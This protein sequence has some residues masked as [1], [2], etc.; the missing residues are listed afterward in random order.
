MQKILACL[1][2]CRLLTASQE[3][4]AS[5]KDVPMIETTQQIPLITLNP[6]EYVIAKPFYENCNIYTCCLHS[7]L[8]HRN[9][10]TVFTDDRNNPTFFLVCSPSTPSNLNAPV[11]LAGKLDQLTLKKI[12]SFLKTFPKISLVAPMNWEHRSLFEEAGFKA[13]ERL[14][15]KRPFQSFD[16]S[17]WKESLPSHYSV[18]EMNEKNFTQCKW[19]PFVLSCYGDKDRFFTTGVGFCILDQERVI[20]ESYGLFIAN[21]QA[22]IGVI[23]DPEYRGQNLGT[24]GCA[25]ML[26]YCYKNNLE[27]Y[28]NCDVKNSASAAIAKKLGFEEDSPYLFLKWITP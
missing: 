1:F 2:A 8:E 18:A 3:N 24:I 28:W 26:D 22:E 11:Y 4:H 27:P 17:S 12:A 21:G 20:S 25:I 13:V 6:E 14:Q 16:M 9:A 19:S 23:T 10:G 15:L 5:S 7:I